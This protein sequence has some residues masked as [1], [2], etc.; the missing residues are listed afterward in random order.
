MASLTRQRSI[1]FL[2]ALIT[3]IGLIPD[4][5]LSQKNGIPSD[6]REFW[7]GYIR[8]TERIYWG[9]YRGYYALVTSYTDNT[10]TVNY[11]DEAGKEIQG[12]SYQ[13]PKYGSK[14][15][16]LDPSKMQ[17]SLTGEDIA[18]HSAR[19]KSKNPI[20]VHFYSEGSFNGAL[21]QSFPT[22]TLGKKYVVASHFDSPA[23]S[24]IWSGD[25]A[26]STFLIIAP[27][28]NTS[29]TITPNATTMGGHVGVNSGKGATG[30]PKPYTI[31]MMR[32]QTYQVMSPPV[33]REHDMSGTTIESSKPVAV[34][35]GHQR[36]TI[37]DPGEQT[38][39]LDADFRDMALEQMIPV[40]SWEREGYISIPFYEV[41]FNTSMYDGG[42]GDLYRFYTDE[43]SDQVDIFEGGITSPYNY[44]IGRYAYP[45][46]ER[47]NVQTAVNA[48]S[49]FGKKFSMIQYDLFQA[50]LHGTWATGYMSPG[51]CNVVPE[52]K[53]RKNYA[54]YVPTDS[55]LKGGQYLNVIAPADQIDKIQLI[56]NG[57]TK[58]PLS[59][60]P[61][62][63]TY[64]IPQRPDLRGYQIKATPGSY[65]AQSPA[66][67][68]VYT[69]GFENGGYKDNY[70][71]VSTVGASFGS[72]DESNM[73][74]IVIT[75]N[76]SSWDVVL[77]DS[78]AEDEGLAQV[79]L[80]NDPDGYFY[81]PPFVSNN[82]RMNPS[83]PQ[84]E[85]GIK[86][87]AFRIQVQ[88]PF[89]DAF[90]AVWVV[91]KA[92]N[93]TVYQFT[94]R[95]PA[96]TAGPD[97]IHFGALDVGMEK[98][99]TFTFTNTAL[100]G[101]QPV[102]IEDIHLLINDPDIRIKSI[103][104]TLPTSLQGGE[105]LTVDVC[106]T[107][108]DAPNLHF[109]SLMLKTDCFEAALAIMGS[110]KAPSIYAYD[111]DFGTIA[112]GS[113][114][115]MKV[116]VENV[117]TSSFTLTKD[118]VLHNSTEFEF[119]DFGQLPVI[120]DPGKSTDLEFVYKPTKITNLD[121]TT[122]DWGTDM[123]AAFKGQK[124][125]WSYLIG[126]AVA[127]EVV[128][129]QDIQYFDVECAASDTERVYLTNILNSQEIVQDVIIYGPDADEFSFVRNELNWV[130]P[131]DG[132]PL[133][134]GAMVWFDVVFKPNLAKG[135][136]TRRATLKSIT[137]KGIDDTMSLAAHVFY[138]DLKTE[139]TDLD[140]G[141]EV[142]G[143]T[144]KRLVRLSNPG[145]AALIVRSATVSDPAFKIISGIAPGDKININGFT[146]VEIEGTAPQ[147]GQV[148]AQLIVTGET[149]CPPKIDIPMKIAGYYPTAQ[150]TGFAAPMTFVCRDNTQEIEFRNGAKAV[151]LDKVEILDATG[152][153]SQHF[154]FTD[155]SRALVLNKTI[156][157][158]AIERIPVIF[159]PMSV[160]P[161]GSSAIVR[162]TW[163][164]PES[165]TT[166][167]IEQ[168][169][170]GGSQ[171]LDN[172]FSVAKPDNT[173]YTADPMERFSVDV[174]ML[175]D[176]IPEGDIKRA[177]FGISYQQDL[178]RFETFDAGE[179]LSAVHTDP[180]LTSNL[181]DTVWVDVTG[182][183]TAQDIL[184]TIQFTLLL[185]KDLESPFTIID[186]VMY[187]GDGREA[188]YMTID[189]VPASFI[190][191][192]Y[193]GTL[194]LRDYLNDKL[195]TSVIRMTPN[196][197]KNKISLTYDVNL[198]DV[199]VTIEMFDMLGN[200]VLSQIEGKSHSI[201]RFTETM[202]ASSLSSGNYIVRITSGGQVTS[203][204]VLIKH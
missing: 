178:F 34:I 199:L 79:E 145:T 191:R 3:L 87:L 19:I 197:A 184:G 193:C 67:F 117:G 140:F 133:D 123:P 168:P 201:G 148:D 18:F 85:P 122:V 2:F 25:S 106:Y 114:K 59:A 188:C 7:L 138:A 173:V 16:P 203:R 183:L 73:P 111:V 27:F 190:P 136:G 15:I 39:N 162:Y 89:K 96:F 62:L 165:K 130:L 144:V 53:W 108:T 36:A 60:L 164:H 47:D 5:A 137:L 91:D 54:W 50:E 9:N 4:R 200:K 43:S 141:T 12:Q 125:A 44:Q 103:S 185:S 97:S 192:E 163:T 127:P 77:T 76:C 129:T 13:I 115:T 198:S 139:T 10:L 154:Q 6:G 69:Y 55:R 49:V 65:I 29:V 51:M 146:V 160:I 58:K 156:D 121:S 70:G 174:K 38:A 107:A 109:D 182:D 128:W 158:N 1:V 21:Y 118:W 143:A 11:F 94:Y 24:G 180:N 31:K 151:R 119:T 61:R 131:S 149:E 124:K 166:G 45:N 153:F 179:G 66:P 161:M 157:A 84:F 71:Y 56:L 78:S 92:G 102:R 82:V 95:A 187:S 63:K 167:V 20:S 171:V 155:G 40:E 42:K 159:R 99:S 80:L 68:V 110:G 101:G 181:I 194:V 26:S 147:N 30:T 175:K 28:N 81:Q 41:P 195:P 177:H 135:Y 172:T 169:I 170:S 202:D 46:P 100:P 176:I 132:Y 189:D 120:L 104:R 90:A 186:P 88:N 113:K 83:E 93:D 64:N 37:G 75:P 86:T 35:A 134:S 22:A 150:G 112:V 48:R 74:D 126:R 196:P 105:S 72:G 57:G 116:R 98:C 8:G 52:K 14:K 152:S 32:G 17:G 23:S 142:G 204:Q 33:D